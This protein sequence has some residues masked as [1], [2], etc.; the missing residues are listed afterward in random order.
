MAR[1]KEFSRKRTKDDNVHALVRNI[2]NV[3]IK[4]DINNDPLDQGLCENTTTRHAH[5]DINTTMIG[6]KFQ[7]VTRTGERKNYNI[8]SYDP[9][10]GIHCVQRVKIIEDEEEKKYD[11]IHDHK[12]KD[13]A[14]EDLPNIRWLDTV[15]VLPEGHP[16]ETSLYSSRYIGVQYIMVDNGCSSWKAFAPKSKD[17]TGRKKY[18]G[19]YRTE[20]DAALAH[21]CYAREI[22]CTTL[23]FKD[24]F[25]YEEEAKKLRMSSSSSSSSCSVAS[26]SSCD[27]DSITP[28]QNHDDP[29]GISS[30]GDNNS[31]L[32]NEENCP[33]LQQEPSLTTI[34]EIPTQI[35][36]PVKVTT[37][38]QGSY[39][40]T[41]TG[42]EPIKSSTAKK[43]IYR[44]VVCITGGHK[45]N[46]WKAQCAIKKVVQS[47]GRCNGKRRATISIGTYENE[48]EAA[49]AYDEVIRKHGGR[50]HERL[51]NFPEQNNIINV[52]YANDDELHMSDTNQ[53][54]KG[55]TVEK[56]KTKRKRQVD[57][58]ITSE[59]RSRNGSIRKPAAIDDDITNKNNNNKLCLSSLAVGDRI[60]FDFGSSIYFGNIEKCDTNNKVNAEWNWNVSFDD[61]ER[62]KFDYKDMLSS[63]ALY[64]KL[65]KKE[66][67]SL[68]SEQNNSNINKS[69]NNKN[70]EVCLSGLTV[71]DRI[72]FNFGSGIYYGCIEEC[73]TNNKVDAEWNWNV[74][75]DDGDRYVFDCEE[76]STAITLYEELKMNEMNDPDR[77]KKV[78]KIKD[79]FIIQKNYVLSTIP[80]EV[81]NHFLQVGFALWQ[82][83]YLPALF[84]GPYDVSPGL[85][86][87]E[88]LAA[89]EKCDNSNVPQIVY[90]FGS[91]NLADAFSI[92]AKRSCISLEEGKR[93]GL[94]K[95]ARSASDSNRFNKAWRH[96]KVAMKKPLNNRSPFEKL[97]EEYEYVG[98]DQPDRLL[99]ELK[100]ATNL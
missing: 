81:K 91:S 2:N 38:K 77:G 99:V 63:V 67:N 17:G 97:K 5:H 22:G 19:T 10:N 25:I 43:S 78:K 73:D 55:L 20:R 75:F 41:T 36:E 74:S 40:G 62:Y 44:G 94:L 80:K 14:M 31:K 87:D 70:N 72:A 79:D 28:Q 56:E 52:Q 11:H 53:N 23:N 39:S 33:N 69:N 61:G 49:V 95:K 48:I 3:N 83:M 58:H 64:E 84:L 89:F 12:T 15:A 65:K 96:L 21:D 34:N 50:K 35:N 92:R 30:G 46:K 51:L 18:V 1:T 47:L 93:K 42:E 8:L 100:A 7:Y 37:R 85:V 54:R 45:S 60:A 13:I 16:K 6:R 27:H 68:H 4:K 86:R 26:L 29:G 57:E 71:G 32:Q 82:K 88:W 59:K 9:K 98:G 76:M 90:W 66:M 24:E